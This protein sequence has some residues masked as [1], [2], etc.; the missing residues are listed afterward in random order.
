ML[1]YNQATKYH[2]YTLNRP[3]KPAAATHQTTV[4][5]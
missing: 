4:H 3:T 5:N 1:R 2:G